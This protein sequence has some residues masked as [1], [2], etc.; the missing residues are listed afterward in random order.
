MI[1][2]SIRPL[3]HFRCLNR[4]APSRL[5]Y[6]SGLTCEDV[7]GATG[8]H[9]AAVRERFSVGQLLKEKFMSFVTTQPEML[10]RW[11]QSDK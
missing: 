5:T 3:H 7:I 10:A 4:L 11:P 1:V 2:S 8:Q 6:A 9:S